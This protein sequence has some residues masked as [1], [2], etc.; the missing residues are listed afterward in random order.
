MLFGVALVAAG[1][2]TDAAAAATSTR[3]VLIVTSITL[4]SSFR[5]FAAIVRGRPGSG[6]GRPPDWFAENYASR[7][8]VTADGG[9]PGPGYDSRPGHDSSLTSVTHQATVVFAALGAGGQAAA[10][11]LVAVIALA[12]IGVR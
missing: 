5:W 12:A 2:S 6:N 8:G 10:G 7:P 3:P 4:V 1:A 11:G 9:V